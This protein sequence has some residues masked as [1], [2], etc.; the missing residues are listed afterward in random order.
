MHHQTH[1]IGFAIAGGGAG[2]LLY[3]LMGF[4]RG[5]T[6]G[7]QRLNASTAQQRQGVPFADRNFYQM[8][9]APIS[10]AVGALCVIVGVIWLALTS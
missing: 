4:L 7:G 2:L 10:A 6:D 1:A 5:R 9:G 8:K 3:A